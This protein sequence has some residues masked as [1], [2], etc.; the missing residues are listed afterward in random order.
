MIGK[1]IDAWALLNVL[2]SDTDIVSYEATESP[3]RQSE[4][5]D[6]YEKNNLWRPFWVSFVFSSFFWQIDFLRRQKVEWRWD[7]WLICILSVIIDC[8]SLYRAI[9]LWSPTLG[10]WESRFPLTGFNLFGFL[11]TRWFNRLI[12]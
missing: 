11:F 3:D 5:N 4:L 2:F 9:S 6:I 7:I 10:N 12:Y 1:L 8:L